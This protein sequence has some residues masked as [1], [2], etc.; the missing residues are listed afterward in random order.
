VSHNAII[1]NETTLLA[2]PHI[3]YGLSVYLYATANNGIQML[4]EFHPLMNRGP[5]QTYTQN[6]HVLE[7]VYTSNSFYTTN[8]SIRLSNF[9]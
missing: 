8:I 3:K 6:E 4:Q 7:R 5:K 9:N 1:K 2:Q